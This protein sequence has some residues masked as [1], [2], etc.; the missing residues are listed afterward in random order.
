MFN[1][2]RVAEA[3]FNSR[4][5]GDDS[6]QDIT[7][8]KEMITSNFFLIASVPNYREAFGACLPKASCTGPPTMK[9]PP[10]SGGAKECPEETYDPQPTKLNYSLNKAPCI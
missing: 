9:P 4:Y 3:I 2:I 10:S 7:L 8:Y 6:Y 5:L 1:S